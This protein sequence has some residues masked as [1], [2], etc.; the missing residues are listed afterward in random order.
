MRKRRIRLQS[1]FLG[2]LYFSALSYGQGYEIELNA[3]DFANKQVILAEYFTTRMIPKDTIILNSSGTGVFK[4]EKPFDGGLYVMFF[5]QNNYFD[6]MINR[7]QFF[8]ITTNASDFV[9]KTTFTGSVDNKGFYKYKNFL[10]KR[11]GKQ[12]SYIKQLAEAKTVSDSSWI[13]SMMEKLN[14]EI[15][16]Y[17]DMMIFDYKGTFF[18]T[19]L[20]AM[21]DNTAPESILKGTQKQKD[22]I[23]YAFY[24][25]HYFDNFNVGDIRL[26]HTPLYDAKIKNYIN[27]V[28]PSHPDSL[29]AA[30]DF[31]IERSRANEAIF[32]Y[33][34]ITLFNNFAESKIMGM[35]KVYFHIA[36]KYY[37]PEAHWSDK[38]YIEKLK[39]NL[40]KSKH[41]FIG[42]IAP[43]FELRGLPK[44]HIHMA[45][46]DQQIKEDPHVGYTFSL[47]DIDAEYTIL[48]FWEADCGHCQK[49]TP[50]L[51]EV[52]KKYK[53][54][55]LEVL[56]IHVINSVEGKVKWIDFLNEHE[57]YDWT[58]CWSPYD[59]NFRVLYNLT[60][61]PY[62]LLLDK[63]KRIIAKRLAPEQID[64][65]LEKLTKD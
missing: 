51:Y 39:E 34:L 40:E 24:K 46:M 19:F 49:S 65:M 15:S 18:A 7:D 38:E 31:L 43:D 63:D 64:D 21:R 47:S 17:V 33:M 23:R 14:D 28:V 3:P 16:Q 25:N 8:S 57:L 2:M 45:E 59:N 62:L 1:A 60:S 5:D 30:V 6:F 4:G 10:A 12:E 48:Y 56:S 53:D 41:T 55:G 13:S 42:E 22:S 54:K 32:R 37:I 27:K 52:F 36:K 20:M 26:L 11:R 50:K 44:E 9:K 35:D 61:F 58:N 29:I